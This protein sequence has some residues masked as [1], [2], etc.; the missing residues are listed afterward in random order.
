MSKAIVFSI[1]ESP[2][3]PKL[4]SLYTELG[5]DEMQFHSMRKVMSA[6]KSQQPDVIIAEFFYK[7]STNYSSN[8]ISNLDSLLTTLY[9]YPDYHPQIILMV[10]KKELEFVSQLETHYKIDHVLTQPVSEEQIR[11]LLTDQS[12]L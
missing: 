9:K 5:Y 4:S 11:K 3:H 8:H 6:L 7:Y 1:I 10:S 12:L 2:L